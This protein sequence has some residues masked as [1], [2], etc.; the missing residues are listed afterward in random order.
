MKPGAQACGPI[1]HQGH[2]RDARPVAVGAAASLEPVSPGPLYLR[3]DRNGRVLVNMDIVYRNIS[4]ANRAPP[5]WPL[6]C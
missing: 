3:R 2:V 4:D 6:S 5:Y 1:H